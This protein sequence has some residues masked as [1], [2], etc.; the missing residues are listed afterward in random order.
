M[1]QLQLYLAIVD[2]IELDAIVE[3][4][5]IGLMAEMLRAV[6]AAEREANDDRES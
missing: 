1:Q 6:L 5:L 4:Q 2:R 3:E